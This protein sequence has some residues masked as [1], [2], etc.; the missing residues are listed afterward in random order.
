MWLSILKAVIES[1]VAAGAVLPLGRGLICGR[2]E[3]DVRFKCPLWGQAD[4]K[5]EEGS[6]PQ[7][8]HA[9]VLQYRRQNPLLSFAIIF[10]LSGAHT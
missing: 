6:I 3:A 9:G 1:T 8:V 5:S 2:Q 4:I 7:H 10:C